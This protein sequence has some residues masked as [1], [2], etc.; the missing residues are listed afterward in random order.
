MSIQKKAKKAL[1]TGNKIKVGGIEFNKVTASSFTLCEMLNLTIISGESSKCPQFEILA[2]L[3]LHFIGAREA[4]E[5]VF[6][7]SLGQ[8]PNGRSLAFVHA[9]MDW[10]DEMSFKDYTTMA[11][12]IGMMLDEGFEGAVE[13]QA[14]NKEG[15][16]RK[17]A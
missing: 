6:D 9:C 2:F 13:V 16:G 1:L 17:V 7:N 3:Y 11:Q 15:N 12:G 8:D 5:L 4:R 10:A 14:D